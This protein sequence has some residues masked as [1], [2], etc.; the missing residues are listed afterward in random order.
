M[1][2]NHPCLEMN[3]ISIKTPHNSNNNKNQ[4]T[5][6]PS[7]DHVTAKFYDTRKDEITSILYNFSENRERRSISEQIILR[8]IL[9]FSK[10]RQLIKE[11]KIRE[12][13]HKMGDVKKKLM[14]NWSQ[15][16]LESIIHETLSLT[17]QTE[18]QLMLLAILTE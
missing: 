15:W 13:L 17:E 11:K 9:S 1:S 7:P 12:L 10:I 16:H 18:N 6:E 14:A 2:R 5:K 8:T 3:Y 4:P